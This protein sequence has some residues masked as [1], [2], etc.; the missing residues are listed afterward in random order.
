MG[1]VEALR[2]LSECKDRLTPQ[3]IRTIRGQI[4]AGNAGAAMRGLARILEGGAGRGV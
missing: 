4:L 1:K 2:R 3:Q